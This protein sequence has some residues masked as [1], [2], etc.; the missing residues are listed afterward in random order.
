MRTEKSPRRIAWSAVRRLV[1][2]VGE[3]CSA[4]G[5][6]RPMVTGWLR[7]LVLPSVRALGCIR[8]PQRADARRLAKRRAEAVN[9][10]SALPR[11]LRQRKGCGGCE[12][13]AGGPPSPRRRETAPSTDEASKSISQRVLPPRPPALPCSSRQGLHHAVVHN[14][15]SAEKVPWQ[16]AVPVLQTGSSARR[17]P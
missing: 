6:P 9:G 2:S 8:G 3:G 16:Q 4:N 17:L 15:V 1:R 14:A 11:K 5:A 7:F 10:C 12:P 13:K